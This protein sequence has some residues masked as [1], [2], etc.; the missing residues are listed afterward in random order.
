MTDVTNVRE[1]EDPFWVAD[2]DSIGKEAKTKADRRRAL[3][4]C[5]EE[6]WSDENIGRIERIDVEEQHG[7]EMYRWQRAKNV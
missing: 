2:L 1:D 5:L 7:W 4:A 3:E 6:F